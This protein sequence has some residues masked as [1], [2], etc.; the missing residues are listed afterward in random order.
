LKQKEFVKE[1]IKKLVEEHNLEIE[2][3][4]E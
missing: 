3:Y 1:H 4:T 2:R